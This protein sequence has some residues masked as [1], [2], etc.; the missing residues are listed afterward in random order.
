VVLVCDVQTRFRPLV[1]GC[2]SLIA[3][4]AFLLQCA[5]LL[6]CPV[7]AT[8]Q[9]PEKLGPTVP[10]LAGLLTGAPIAKTSFSMVTPE[11]RSRLDAM[12]AKVAIVVGLETHVCV[13]QTAQD[14]VHLGIKPY[15]VVD[16]VS[17]MRRFERAVALRRLQAVGAVLTTAESIIFELLGSAEHP[18]FRAISK[19]TR[20]H[21]ELASRSPLQSLE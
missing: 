7:I 14:L 17:S 13:L 20:D 9:A 15:V 10:E 12:S 3:S 8:E 1:F 11:V 21:A 18:H 5:A 2:E 4:A 19:L 16:A 6:E